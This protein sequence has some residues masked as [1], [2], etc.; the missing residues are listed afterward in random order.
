[1][2]EDVNKS[3]GFH[4]CFTSCKS[5]FCRSHPLTFTPSCFTI[6]TVVFHIVLLRLKV[7]CLDLKSFRHNEDMKGVNKYDKIFLPEL[8]G[9][10]SNTIS[11]IFYH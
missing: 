11:F 4:S 5:P 10:N 9:I 1:M 8:V 3:L 6:W 2:E 7:G